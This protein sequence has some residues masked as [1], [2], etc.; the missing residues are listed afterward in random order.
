MSYK[1]KCAIDALTRE[2]AEKRVTKQYLVLT[3][4]RGKRPSVLLKPFCTLAVFEFVLTLS[5]PTKG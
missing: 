4:L 5:S 1:N 2:A 3:A